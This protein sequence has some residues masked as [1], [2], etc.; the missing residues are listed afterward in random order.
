M[1]NL[2]KINKNDYMWKLQFG[3]RLELIGEALNNEDSLGNATKSRSIKLTDE[4]VRNAISGNMLSHIFTKNL[5]TL[6]DKEE[7]CDTC[8]IFSPM[9]N[10][11]VVDQD[12]NLSASGNRVK[13]CLID[14]A[15]GF[16]NAGKGCNEKRSKVLNFAWGIATQGTVDTALYNRVDPTEKNS[17]AKENQDKI[18][19]DNGKEIID[20]TSEAN[21]NKDQNT[22][23]IFHRPV[24][25]SEYAIMTQIN[26]SRVAFDDEKQMYV[27]DDKE[28]IK[29]RIRKI[30]IAYRNTLLD[31][32][33]A[34]CA[35]NMPHLKGISGVVVE[36]TSAE[37]L[38]SK[39]SPLNED[40][41]EIHKDLSN[42][43]S[44]NTIKEFIEVIERFLD[45]EYLDFM[46]ERN[47]KHVM[48]F[49]NR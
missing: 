11:K 25:S 38:M 41:M 49:F 46:V 20:T 43:K 34:M 16:M 23:M 28:K 48:N 6:A 18:L 27:F 1:K 40:Y 15:C 21:T 2:N 12:K 37:E 3:V 39:Y 4:E 10:G 22:Q 31:I 14:D 36:K 33:G 7:L 9:K 17:K 30:I 32:E 26:L 47:T 19:D 42:T 35:T 5:R 13:A 8:K 24:R 45:E 29:A 44:F